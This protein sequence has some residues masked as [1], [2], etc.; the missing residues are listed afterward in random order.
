[1]S[2]H[3]FAPRTKNKYDFTQN[4]YLEMLT[5]TM[6]TTEYVGMIA[7][8]SQFNECLLYSRPQAYSKDNTQMIICL[9]AIVRVDLFGIS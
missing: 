9:S 7:G 2:E 4:T 1:M 6:N 5:I 8:L 3:V